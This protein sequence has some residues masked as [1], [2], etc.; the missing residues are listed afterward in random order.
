M[1]EAPSEQWEK[2][3][4]LCLIINELSLLFLTW[5]VFEL[6]TDNRVTDSYDNGL[7]KSQPAEGS[8]NDSC[9][10]HYD[11]EGSWVTFEFEAAIVINGHEILE[12]HIFTD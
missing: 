1:Q 6:S 11:I 4:L 5:N 7:E 8:A 2:F 9:P 3:H 12:H 10:E